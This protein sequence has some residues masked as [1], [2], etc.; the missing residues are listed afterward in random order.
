METFESLL[1]ELDAVI[2]Q[3]N[4]EAYR[5]LLPPLPAEIVEKELGNIGI[6]DKNV[7][8]LFHWKS[9]MKDEGGP[10]FMEHGGLIT[11]DSIKESNDF[12]Q[13]Y[14]PLLIPL[15]SDN[16]EDMLMFNT[17]AG[18]HYGKMYLFSVPLL[19]VKHPI[20]YYDSLTTMVKTTIEAYR[21]R[22]YQYDEDDNG[23]LSINLDKFSPIARK[24]NPNSAYW[25]ERK[26]KKWTEYYEI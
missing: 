25:T 15:I 19:L 13:H 5:N 21:E 4:P 10:L 22:A 8:L 24:Y 18:A 17:N 9:G 3:Y 14:D 26:N 23:C 1:V 6:Y 7:R 16:G 11:F 20:S 2:R 12:N